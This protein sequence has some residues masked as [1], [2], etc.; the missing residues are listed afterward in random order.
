MSELQEEFD[1]E[2][3]QRLEAAQRKAADTFGIPWE[4]FT[5]RDIRE[6]DAYGA[7]MAAV[8]AMHICGVLD[9][10][11]VYSELTDYD[12]H[13]LKN[14]DTGKRLP[15]G[16][17]ILQMLAAQ[18]LATYRQE[19]REDKERLL[20]ARRAPG[21]DDADPLTHTRLYVLTTRSRH[22]VALETPYDWQGYLMEELG[23][24]TRCD[25]HLLHRCFDHQAAPAVR[26]LV[27]KRG[28]YVFAWKICGECLDALSW[29]QYGDPRYAG[30]YRKV[31]DHD[32]ETKLDQPGDETGTSDADW[33]L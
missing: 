5:D 24:V 4:P 2:V 13:D 29:I 10:D 31:L 15:Q 20:D 1:P 11:G 30:P 32:P 19:C 23:G 33:E 17:V 9:E 22:A 27:Y 28:E 18:R 8:S 7:A 6:A 3:L 21:Y 12:T 26:T 25:V 14:P 16:D